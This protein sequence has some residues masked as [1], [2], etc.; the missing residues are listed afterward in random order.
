MAIK[1]W[2]YLFVLSIIW[3][4]SYIL[5]K[6]GLIGLTPLQLGSIRIF[7]TTAILLIFGFRSL[8]GLTKK[9][10]RWI[11]ITGYFGT[12]F[13]SY[14]FAVS[15][16]VINS[17]VAAV[18]NGMTPLFTL[19]I[20]LFYFKMAFKR[21][22]FI[23]ILVGFLGTVILVSNEF[24]ISSGHE[25]SYALL[26]VIA[27]ACYAVN[28]NILKHKLS[29]VSPMA[30]AV[31]NFIGIL[32]PAVLLF[33]FSDFSFSKAFESAAIQESLGYIF[34][35]SFFGTAVAKVMFNDL[36]SISSPVFSISITYL[37]PIVA[38]GWGLLDQETFSEVQWLAC[39]FILFGVYLVTDKK[40][41]LGKETLLKI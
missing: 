40:K 21:M 10:W 19:L 23:G 8:K 14:L 38:I 5:I 31:G 33:L 34:I 22:Q 2:V 39:A 27:A 17:S 36:V 41:R 25:G 29:G 24:S 7:F 9:A 28:V 32:P 35:L 30:I 1:K 18:L 4:S 37:L 20:G 26:V 12:F 6:K 15:E 11:L 16:T 3:G 13:P